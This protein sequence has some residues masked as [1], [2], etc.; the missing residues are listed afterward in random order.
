MLGFDADERGVR[1]LPERYSAKV[2]WGSR[3]PHDD[4]TSA[5]DA[6]AMLT[7]ANVEESLIARMMGENAA[8]QFGI[9]LVQTVGV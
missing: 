9:A 5:W 3:Y 2:V 1:K 7:R 6:I 8:Q 4:T